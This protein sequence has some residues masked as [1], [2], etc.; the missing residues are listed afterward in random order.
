MTCQTTLLN[1][2]LIKC[3]HCM[4]WFELYDKQEKIIPTKC[5]MLILLLILPIGE[6]YIEH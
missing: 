3:F 4:H 5:G 1:R 6:W 2:Y